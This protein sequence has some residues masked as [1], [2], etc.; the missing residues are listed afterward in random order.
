[1]DFTFTPSQDELATRV[2]AFAAERIAPYRREQDRGGTYRPGLFP[3]MAAADLFALRIPEE[4]GG[5]GLDAVSAGIA[6]EQLA[7]ADLSVCFPVLNAA[8]IGGVLADNGDPEQRAAWLPPIARGDAVVALALTEPDHGTDAAGIRMEARPDGDGW[9]LTGEKT[10]IMIAAHAT[11]GLVFARTGGEGARG[12]SAFYVALDD[13]RVRREQLTDLGCRAGGRGRIVLDG[14]R[15]GPRDLVGEPGGGFAAVMRGFGVSRALI[16]LMAVAVGDAALE[17]AYAHAARRTAFGRP[18]GQFQSVSFPL[19]EHT[20]LLHAARLVAY[21]ALCRADR[22]EDPRIP[23]NM[24]KWWAPK[25]AV[26]ATHQALLTMGHLGWSEDG[27]I[28]QRLRDV[29]GLQLADGTAAA[30]KLTVARLVL[31]KEYAP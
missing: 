28:A 6:L 31:G 19:V 7:A 8:L 1:M 5:L 13:A 21:E 9:L 29:I 15:V 20:T 16:A 23:S 24:A 18:L 4:Y 22:G 2:G 30:T 27:P 25:A 3:D 11:H 14:L 12:I 10:S 26:E 17:E